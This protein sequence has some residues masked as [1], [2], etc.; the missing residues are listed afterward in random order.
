MSR[1]LDI[2]TRKNPEPIRDNLKSGTNTV[3]DTDLNVP[4][5][6]RRWDEFT[7]ENITSLFSRELNS[8]YNGPEQIHRPLEQ[9]ITLFQ[10]N[11]VEDFLRRFIVPDVNYCYKPE[12]VCPKFPHL[13]KRPRYDRL[14]PLTPNCDQRVT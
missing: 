7:Y 13:Y 12:S 8:P 14:P 2:L 4:R 6:W 3:I 1:I 11:T 9:D 5:N 10:E